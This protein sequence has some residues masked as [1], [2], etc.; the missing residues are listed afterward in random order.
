MRKTDSCKIS[1]FSMTKPPQPESFTP[2]AYQKLRNRFYVKYIAISTKRMLLVNVRE[3]KALN[4]KL[5][6]LLTDLQKQRFSPQLQYIVYKKLNK[7]LGHQQ[8]LNSELK[9]ENCTQRNYLENAEYAA[10]RIA[11][12][13]KFVEP[14][15]ILELYKRIRNFK[16]K[17]FDLTKLLKKELKELH[18][19]IATSYHILNHYMLW[20]RTEAL[21]LLSVIKTNM[22]LTADNLSCSIKT[23]TFACINAGNFDQQ[24]P[25]T[26]R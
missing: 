19:T 7:W 2:V 1:A 9:Q 20:C 8:M 25:H 26:T 11:V 10:P 4:T 21:E 3:F 17:D 12:D 23:R 24:R 14:Q 18:Q 15:K 22:N 13:C 6:G 5:L 16:K